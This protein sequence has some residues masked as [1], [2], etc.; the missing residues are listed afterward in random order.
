MFRPCYFMFTALLAMHVASATDENSQNQASKP[1]NQDRVLFEEIDQDRDGRLDP[2]EARQSEELTRYFLVWDTDQ[3]GQLDA[4]EVRA[5]RN[6]DASSGQPNFTVIEFAGREDFSQLDVDGDGAIAPTEWAEATTSMA[7]SA[8]DT[9]ANGRL[10]ESEFADAVEVPV[11]ESA[12]DVINR[13]DVATWDDRDEEPADADASRRIQI[14]S[15]DL[16]GAV[17]F[18]ALD[19][20][21]NGM[22]DRLEATD[23]NYVLANFEEWDADNNDVLDPDEVSQ[24]RVELD[25]N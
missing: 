13:E 15:D 11:A 23:N 12:A 2:D 24:A 14:M 25:M 8:A 20:D 10:D 1:A 4:D 5:G 18:T 22:I 7:F 21:D 17:H 3:N 6:G 19:T 16:T 9:D